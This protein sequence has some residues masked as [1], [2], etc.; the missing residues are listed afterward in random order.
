MFL[1]FA[2][3]GGLFLIA[4][5]PLLL[6]A[7]RVRRFAGMA[8][9]IGALFAILAV[10]WPVQEQRAAV[11]TTHLDD[12]MPVWQFSEQHATRVA[13][14]PERVFEAIRAVTPNEILFFRTLTA[15]RRIGRPTPPNILNAPEN[16]PLLHLATR[17][18]FRYLADDPPRE[19]VVGTV[20]VPPRAVL[21][22][23][24]FLVKP[25]GQGGSLLSTETRVFADSVSARRNFSLYWRIIH[26]G[27]DIIRRMWL[28]AIKKR[29]ET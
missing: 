5:A 25:D 6:I 29:A 9:L 8:V 4:V 19:L 27:S 11:R 1:S 24:N 28:R 3:Y 26:P 15:I 13:A 22:T 7:R 21:A 10:A 18:S 12:A 2:L 17:T 23:M 16:E 20:I 14:T